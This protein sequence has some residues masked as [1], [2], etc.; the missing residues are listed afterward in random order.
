M[1]SRFIVDQDAVIRAADVNLDHT[2]RPEPD[3]ATEVLRILK[4]LSF[5]L[6]TPI[7]LPAV[8]SIFS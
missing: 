8:G 3:T 5:D 6:P 2:I 1:P 4:R 7:G